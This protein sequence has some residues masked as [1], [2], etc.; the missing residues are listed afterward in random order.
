MRKRVAEKILKNREKLH[1]TEHQIKQA[2]ETLKELE[3]RRA[4]KRSKSV[5]TNTEGGE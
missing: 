3:K 2:E 5:Q 4:K 1:Y